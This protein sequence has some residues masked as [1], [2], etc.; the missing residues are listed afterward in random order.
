MADITKTPHDAALERHHKYR[1]VFAGPSGEWVLEDLARMCF[2]D[3][4]TLVYSA[5][6]GKVDPVYS[7]YFEGMRTVFLNINKALK[8]PPESPEPIDEGP[9]PIDMED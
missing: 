6:D 5:V 8:P 7:M 3:Q 9:E 4:T 2:R 1:T